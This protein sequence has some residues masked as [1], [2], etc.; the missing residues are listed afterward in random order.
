MNVLVTGSNGFIGSWI[1]KTLRRKY[2]VIG[3]GRSI[4][5]K[6]DVDDYVKWDI[7]KEECPTRILNMKID[8]VVHAVACKDIDDYNDDLIYTN[9]MGTYRIYQLV[10]QC[11]VKKLIL[12]SSTPDNN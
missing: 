2:N 11:K 9:C 3:C 5:S 8:I 10:E 6:I 7:G 4:T 12:I 1:V